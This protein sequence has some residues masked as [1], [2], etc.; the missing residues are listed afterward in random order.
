MLTPPA[1]PSDVHPPPYF[2]VLDPRVV[3]I[4]EETPLKQR[5]GRHWLVLPRSDDEVPDEL[6]DMG[7]QVPC[8]N[9]DANLVRGDDRWELG[10]GLKCSGLTDDGNG[11]PTNGVTII[12]DLNHSMFLRA[13]DQAMMQSTS[14]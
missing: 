11:Y 13:L 14:S 12:A 9:F 1:H 4:G 7:Y 8:I 6:V 10:L 3:A 5:S 2:Q